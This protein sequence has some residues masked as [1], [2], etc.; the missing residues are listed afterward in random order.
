MEEEEA[1]QNFHERRQFA[2]AA[3]SATMHRRGRTAEDPAEAE[4]RN[5]IRTNFSRL[6]RESTINC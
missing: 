1:F 5:K 6:V 3:A 2:G 4:R